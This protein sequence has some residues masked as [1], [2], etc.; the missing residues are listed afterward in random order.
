M[1]QAMDS[2]LVILVLDSTSSSSISEVELIENELYNICSKVSSGTVYAL[3]CSY[4]I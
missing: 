3:L 2:D 4:F 1:S